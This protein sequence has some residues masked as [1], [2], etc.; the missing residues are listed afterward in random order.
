MWQSDAARL[1][2][3]D[4]Q[5]HAPDATPNDASGDGGEGLDS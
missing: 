4:A 5:D 3:F 2:R 1:T